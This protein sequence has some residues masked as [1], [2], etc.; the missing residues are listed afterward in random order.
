MASSLVILG[1]AR[2]LWADVQTLGD[3]QADWMAVNAA[4][5]FYDRPIQHWASSHPEWFSAWAKIRA[6]LRIGPNIVGNCPGVTF[7]SHKPH[8]DW[9]IRVWPEFKPSSGT[10]SLFAVRVGLELYEQVIL[11]GIPLDGSG[12][13]YHPPWYDYYDY[14]EK[15]WREPWVKA[16]PGFNGRV[17][18][19]SG[20]TRE[21]LGGL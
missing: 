1:S 16:A 14:H 21:L 8:H 13:F 5:C 10:S 9:Q 19:M 11:C 3:I 2:C 6:P 12:S 17:R 4:G 20:F 15:K 18:S 7:H